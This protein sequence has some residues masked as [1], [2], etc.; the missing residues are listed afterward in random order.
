M[1]N[2]WSVLTGLSSKVEKNSSNWKEIENSSW[3]KLTEEFTRKTTSNWRIFGQFWRSKFEIRKKSPNW[4]EFF[5]KTSNSSYCCLPS[6]HLTVFF[7]SF[8][9]FHEFCAS[10]STQKLQS[11]KTWQ[12]DKNPSK[13]AHVQ[14]RKPTFACFPF[15]FT[16]FSWKTW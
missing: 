9:H 5:V 16:I 3:L 12:L 14:A 2:F 13:L 15:T 4:R 8:E 1:A 7:S 10:F 11:F 6:S